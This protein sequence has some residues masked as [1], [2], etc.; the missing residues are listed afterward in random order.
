LDQDEDIFTVCQLSRPL[1][2]DSLIPEMQTRYKTVA[3]SVCGFLK[4]V[5]SGSGLGFGFSKIQFWVWVRVL[6]LKIFQKPGFWV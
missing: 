2:I 5:T 3:G 4:F 1:L 6:G